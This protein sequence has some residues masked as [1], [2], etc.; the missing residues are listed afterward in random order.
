MF[1]EKESTVIKSA[2]KNQHCKNDGVQQNTTGLILKFPPN[3]IYSIDE[4]G[5]QTV[6]NYRSTSRQL[7][8]KMYQKKLL[9]SKAR[10]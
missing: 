4:T 10:Q 7:E 3:R 6:P 5:I 2:A 8:R 1:H 9:L